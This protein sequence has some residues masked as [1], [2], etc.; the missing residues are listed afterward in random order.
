METSD[1]T[2]LVPVRHPTEPRSPDRGDPRA[3]RCSRLA[4]NLP[5]KQIARP[6][7]LDRRPSDKAESQGMSPPDPPE[8]DRLSKL[9]FDNDV[10]ERLRAGTLAGLTALEKARRSINEQVQ[11]SLDALNLP[12]REQVEALQATLERAYNAHQ[13]SWIEAVPPNLIELDP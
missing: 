9:I 2:P 8:P 6:T 5:A 12:S 11:A 13:Q 3:S 1:L 10:I 4:I 7:R